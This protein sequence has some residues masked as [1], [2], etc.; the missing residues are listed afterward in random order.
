MKKTFFA[1]IFIFSVF[2][3]S[4]AMSAKYV[5]LEKQVPTSVSKD[6]IEV[7]EVF[8]YGC[9]HCYHLEAYVQ[10]WLKTKA[11]N[12]V[13]VRIPAPL[14]N[15]WEVHARAYYIA[16]ALGAVEKFHPLLFKEILQKNNYLEDKVKIADFFAK[17]GYNKQKIIELYDSFG[18]NSAVVKARSQV[19]GY[20]ITSVPQIVVDG[21]YVINA[22]TAKG[23]ANIFKVTDEL[24][25]KLNKAK[26]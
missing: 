5:T 23:E 3:C 24:I 17:H 13:F 4:N 8:W 9:G 12:V 10:K 16:D 1:F 25:K 6:K 20:K 7:V 22:G 19:M 2:S 15:F 21:K 18:I 26:K 14:N 11:E